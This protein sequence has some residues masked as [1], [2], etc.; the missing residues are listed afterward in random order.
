M[1]ERLSSTLAALQAGLQQHLLEGD[2]AIEAELLPGRLGVARRLEIYRHA[3]RGRLID[4]LRDAY[5]H[6]ASYL[7]ADRFQQDALDYIEGHPSRD[8]SLRS[9]GN[10]W[11]GWLSSRYP[12][13]GEVAELAALDWTL[14]EAFDGPDAEP[15]T[16]AALA[17]VAP[18]DW[19]RAR[20]HPH[21]TSRRLRQRFNTLAVWHAID[22][23]QEPPAAKPQRPPVELLVWRVGHRPHF[24]SLQPVEAAAVDAVAA[25]H[26]FTA[27]CEDVAARFP[28]LEVAPEIGRLLR[29][30]IDEQW[31]TGLTF[32]SACE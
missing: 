10:D 20:F 25:G 22:S 3:C 13:D 16:I 4:A 8:P 15:L 14:R 17:A 30:W 27:L 2:T 9:Y 19:P 12:D 28:A 31:L 1:T 29:R 24:R 23:D 7:G 26:G 32:E 21:P 5:G 11:P 6:T 18:P